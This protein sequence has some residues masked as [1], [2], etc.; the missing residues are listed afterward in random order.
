MDSQEKLVFY[1]KKIVELE[2]LV[3]QLRLSRRI[4]MNLVE[5]IENEK[6]ILFVQLEKEKQQLKLSNQRYAKWLM[7]NNYRYMELQAN[8]KKTNNLSKD[9]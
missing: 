6:K 1:K 5:K 8:F 2:K 4:L 9:D 3:N 7:Q